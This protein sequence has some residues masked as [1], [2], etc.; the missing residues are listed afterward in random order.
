MYTDI[1]IQRYYNEPGSDN[2]YK[3]FIHD[4]ASRREFR[5]SR[6]ENVGQSRKTHKSVF[7]KHTSDFNLGGLQL[8]ETQRFVENFVN[9]NTTYSRILLNWQTGSGKTIGAL[10]IAQ[11]FVENFKMRK[12][13]NIMDQPTVFVI[14]FTQNIIQE[15]MLKHPS[16]VSPKEILAIEL[17][18]KSY[19]KNPTADNMKEYMQYVSSIKRRFTNR[20][21][22]GYYN[23]I[24]YREFSNRF[25][26][27]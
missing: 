6:Q 5:T 8:H 7:G 16:F 10:S 11:K 13:L 21:K 23:F 26:P 25:K 27:V 18:K 19:N 1:P 15:A 24:G 14:G 3:D 12:N 4:I 17:L 22:G 20:K 9:P 2:E